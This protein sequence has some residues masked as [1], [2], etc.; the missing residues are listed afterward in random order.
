MKKL[1]TAILILISFSV[2]S[3]SDIP[4]T[5]TQP[6]ELISAAQSFTASWVDLGSEQSVLGYNSIAIWI[7]LNI[8]FD[9]DLRVRALAK[10]ESAGSDEYL[11]P[12]KTV[13]TSDVKVESEYIEFNVDADQKSILIFETNNLIPYMQFQIQA[14]VSNAN[15]GRVDSAYITKGFK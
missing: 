11:F 13:G 1:L 15:A 5:R 7:N 3:I 10:H 4:G 2:F 14:G 8:N 12:I 6:A 9:Q